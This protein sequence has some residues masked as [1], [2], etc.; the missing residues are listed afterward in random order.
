MQKSSKTRSKTKKHTATKMTDFYDK[1]QS[2]KRY[3]HLQISTSK[4]LSFLILLSAGLIVAK[5]ESFL[6]FMNGLRDDEKQDILTI[7]TENQKPFEDVGLQILNITKAE[8]DVSTKDVKLLLDNFT[9]RIAEIET[10]QQRKRFVTQL[11]EPI[12]RVVPFDIYTPQLISFV[13]LRSIG[14]VILTKSN[15]QNIL[16]KIKKFFDKENRSHKAPG[17]E[18]YEA[19]EMQPVVS[20]IY[21]AIKLPVSGMYKAFQ[22]HVSGIYEGLEVRNGD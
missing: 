8:K 12:Q 9:N 3:L 14:I 7:S 17:S 18:I 5:K 22:S 2:V 10:P 4:L 13:I 11:L 16:H 15:L 19:I 21:E 20:G 6:K 1:L